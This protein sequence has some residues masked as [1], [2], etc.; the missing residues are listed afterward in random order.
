VPNATE[1]DFFVLQLLDFDDA[2]KTVQAFDKRV[3]NGLANGVSKAH[4]LIGREVLVTEKN[5]LVLQQGG[6]YGL[7]HIGRESLGQIDPVQLGAQG[8][9]NLAND[10]AFIV[11]RS[12][13]KPPWVLSAARQALQALR[14]I[15]ALLFSCLLE[16]TC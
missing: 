7:L 2:R 16:L 10:H 9:C 4:E 5:D 12:L 3:F 8:T 15:L 13:G 1:V 11:S 14:V 6:A